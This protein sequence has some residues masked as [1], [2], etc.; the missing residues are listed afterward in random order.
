MT[1]KSNLDISL[2][3]AHKTVGFDIPS[4]RFEDRGKWIKEFIEKLTNGKFTTNGGNGL[5]EP[6]VGICNK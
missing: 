2:K 6:L 1:Q 3:V 4:V 5:T